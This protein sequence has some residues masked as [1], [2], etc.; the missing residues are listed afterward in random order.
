MSAFVFIQSIMYSKPSIV[1]NV[2]NSSPD[3]YLFFLFNVFFIRNTFPRVMPLLSILCEHI[4][5]IN[6][7]I[8]ANELKYLNRAYIEL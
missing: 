8:R 7:I 6:A 2:N 3:L 5:G 4:Y 1:L